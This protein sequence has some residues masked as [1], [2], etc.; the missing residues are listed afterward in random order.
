MIRSAYEVAFG[1]F[2]TEPCVRPRGGL[3][4]GV[5]DPVF[6]AKEL[7]LCPVEQGRFSSEEEA[8]RGPAASCGSHSGPFPPPWPSAHSPAGQGQ[9]WRLQTKQ[10]DGSL[11]GPG[12]LIPDI[13]AES[14]SPEKAPG[15]PK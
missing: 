9:A 14:W 3:G 1:Q 15:T 5:A 11:G 12:Q 13:T 8:A 7:T 6:E 4:P 2:I 10:G